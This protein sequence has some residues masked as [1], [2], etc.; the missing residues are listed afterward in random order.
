VKARNV[1]IFHFYAF[2]KLVIEHFVAKQG[3]VL[4][5]AGYHCPVR[6]FCSLGGSF[7]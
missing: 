7:A 2:G 6:Y 4:P 1:Q 5:G 3:F